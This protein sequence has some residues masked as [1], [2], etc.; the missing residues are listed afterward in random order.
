MPLSPMTI[1]IIG[2]VVL[3]VL[4]GLLVASRY[5]VAKPNEA[6]ILTGRK[7][8]EV[9]N[10]ETGL[11]STDLS[12][13][14]VVMGGGIFVVPFIQRLHV[15]DLSSRR[16][17]VTIRNA[18][19]GQGIK[20][21]VD[22]VAIVKVG[23]NE[24][25]IRAAAQRF[26]SQQDEIETFTQET[27]AGS[28]RSIVGSLTVEQIIRDRAAFAQRVTDESESSLTG[29][30]LV[31]DTFQIQDITD[32]GTYLSDLGRPESAKVGRLA[33]VAEAEARREAEQAQIAAE[34][35][36]A[37][38]QRAL[39][40]KQAEIQSETD[41]ARAQAAA[42]GPLAQAD[43][44]QA[45]LMEQEK[46]AVA[47]AALKER[48]LDT[49]VRRPADAERYRVETAAEAQRNAAI[50]EAEA[51]KAASIANA[52]ADAE[53]ARLTGVGEKSR[54]SALAEAEAIEGAKRGESEKA[55][56]IAEAEAVRAEGEAKA[57][58]TLA[59]G[60]AEA[61]AMDKRAAAFK[62]YNDAAVLQMLVEVLPSMAEKVASPLGSIDKLT[63]ISSDG[64]SQLPRQVTDTLTQTMQLV[65]D[66]T[67]FDLRALLDR[68]AA[69][70]QSSTEATPTRVVQGDVE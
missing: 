62:N 39:V 52:E 17:M 31:L 55:R 66:A 50:F 11:V 40:L 44:D 56:R 34:Q 33:A 38:S 8:K 65:S 18:V 67:G 60:Q 68:A 21:N 27:L 48:Q 26:L 14:K 64:A 6:F 54:R 5:K 53:K 22:G 36:I 15:L 57:A 37:I 32:D 63:V 70:K 20:L 69:G 45:I 10:P 30:G 59:V 16:I 13:Q 23:G 35:E 7:G 1:A 43:R 42:S 49:E 3:V 61:E 41:A 4:V 25:S 12:G 9:R 2:L 28:L 46:V 29:Q 24:D 58:A 51:H 19:S 47:Q